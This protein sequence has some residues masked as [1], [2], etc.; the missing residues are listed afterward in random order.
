M[1]L[2]G[3]LTFTESAHNDFDNFTNTKPHKDKT[4]TGTNNNSK[5]RNY[6]A[7]VNS[8]GDIVED[9]LYST[10]SLCTSA[11][12][13][14]V[15]RKSRHSRKSKDTE[16]TEQTADFLHHRTLLRT[17]ILQLVH[18]KTPFLKKWKNEKDISGNSLDINKRR[19][20]T[21]EAL[22]YKIVLSAELEALNGRNKR[23]IR[24]DEKR[25]SYLTDYVGRFIGHSISDKMDFSTL[26]RLTVFVR[27]ID[28]LNANYFC[29]HSY[30]PLSNEISVFYKSHNRDF[31]G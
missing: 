17:K 2:N 22:I 19:F 12:R 29:Y 23:R 21:S 10:N 24:T 6:T 3:N 20:A 14:G 30:Y 9:R 13:C 5:N 26:N 7:Y 27:E 4:D 1:K 25:V 11:T 15:C 8:A 18:S 31:M 16:S 28:R